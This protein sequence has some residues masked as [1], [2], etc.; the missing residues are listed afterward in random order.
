MRIG[1]FI[2]FRPD[3]CASNRKAASAKAETRLVD[4]LVPA[5]LAQAHNSRNAQQHTRGAAVLGRVIMG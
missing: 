3:P 1:L 2:E 5:R 4:A